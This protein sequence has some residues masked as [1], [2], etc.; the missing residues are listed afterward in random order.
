MNN[1]RHM[2]LYYWV[3][4]KHLGSRVWETRGRELISALLLAIVT[5]FVSMIFRQ[6][7]SLTALEIAVLAL[8]GWLCVFALGHVAHTP[9]ILCDNNA[10]A[11]ARSQHWGFGVLGLVILIIVAS[12]VTAFGMW[13]WIDREPKIAMPTADPGALGVTIEKQR[14]EIADLTARVPDERSLKVRS[15]E[16]ADEFEHFWQRQPRQPVCKQT[17]AMTPQE[18]QKAIEPC[19]KYFQQ[20]TMD[21]QRLLAPRIMEIVEEFKAKGIDVMNIQNCATEGF[22][23]IPL[24]VQLRAFS[25]RLNAQDVPKR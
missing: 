13:L 16:A 22:C 25:L 6:V 20:R 14:R 18:Q 19:A 24:S 5:F 8:V 11:K 7:D 15:W 10:H 21:Y 4:S 1:L 17:P 3:F 9:V 23:G 2:M 12:S